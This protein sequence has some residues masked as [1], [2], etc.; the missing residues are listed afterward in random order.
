ME[1]SPRLHFFGGYWAFPGGVVEDIDQA[2]G[3]DP[4]VATSI[5]C[6]LRE[7]VKETALIVEGICDDRERVRELV[8]KLSDDRDAKKQWREL[9]DQ[10]G[11]ASGNVRHVCS[12]TTP[13]FMPIRYATEFLH[14][15]LSGNQTPE[16]DRT[17][18]VR[19]QFV[20]PVDAID[21]WTRGQQLIVPP[22]LFL[23]E[24]LAGGDIAAFYKNAAHAAA[25]FMGGKLIPVR[26]SPGVFMAPLDSPTLAPATTTNCMIVG[27]DRLYIL[28]P[29]PFDTAARQRL[30]DALDEFEARGAELAGILL[31]HH[32]RDHV[33]ATA[34][35]S[36]RYGLPVR[37][38]KLTYPHLM[39]QDFKRGEP[40]REGDRI[41]LGTAPDGT[42]DW[43]LKVLHTPGHA[44]D[45]LCYIESRYHAAIVGD[46]LSTISTILIDAPEGHMSTYLASLGRLLAEPMTTLYPAHGPAHRNA[47]SL[48]RH[49]LIHRRQREKMIVDALSSAPQTLDEILPQAYRDTSPEMYDVAARALYAGLEKL[50]EDGVARETPTGWISVSG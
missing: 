48:I 13:D 12:I 20:K 9:L 27:K 14:V 24:L 33:G 19:G 50:A 15:K 36:Q 4:T 5:R 6:A 29:A 42:P 28:D 7:L 43:H 47:H 17:K 26:F 11:N 45:H 41:A 46:M 23:L 16:F 40:L 44:R 32:H 22:I 3:E 38:H 18:I 30:F 1:R 10:S 31:T 8:G 35:L 39:D 2:G 37:A 21:K 25:E 49:Y 34:A